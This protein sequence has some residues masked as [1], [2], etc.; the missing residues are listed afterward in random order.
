MKIIWTALI[1]LLIFPDL[2][3]AEEEDLVYSVGAL[4]EAS[5]EWLGASL[6][7]ISYLSQLEATS[8][9]PK[10]YLNSSDKMHLINELERSGYIVKRER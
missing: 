7:A 2:V 6:A 8:Y 9:I 1:S 4:H 3:Q 5:M 10:D